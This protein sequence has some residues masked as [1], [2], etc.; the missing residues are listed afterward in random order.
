MVA[1][2]TFE[3]VLTEKSQDFQTNLLSTCTTYKRYGVFKG[4]TK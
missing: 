4:C 2:W 3:T 1:I